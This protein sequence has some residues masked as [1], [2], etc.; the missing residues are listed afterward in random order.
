[1]SISAGLGSGRS[2]MHENE[3]KIINIKRKIIFNF[4]V[5]WS[6]VFISCPLTVPPAE[7]SVTAWTRQRAT[8]SELVYPNPT[9]WCW[10]SYSTSLS[11]I[12]SVKYER[13][14]IYKWYRQC[15]VNDAYWKTICSCISGHY[16]H[17]SCWYWHHFLTPRPNDTRQKKSKAAT[18]TGQDVPS[19]GLLATI[20]E[21]GIKREEFQCQTLGHWKPELIGLFLPPDRYFTQ[22]PEGVPW[23]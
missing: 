1:M 21:K 5:R 22:G 23:P 4:E 8:K 18:N 17:I 14:S 12:S 9:V 6:L 15:W 19:L 13:G 20:T 10:D 16:A 3:K 2:E 11:L 7:C